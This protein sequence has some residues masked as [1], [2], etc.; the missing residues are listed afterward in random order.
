VIVSLKA[1]LASSGIAITT[2]SVM[3]Y[4]ILIWEY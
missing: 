2:A 3:F 4:C 1:G